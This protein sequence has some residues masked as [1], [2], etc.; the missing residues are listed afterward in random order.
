MLKHFN[1]TEVE[2]VEAPELEVLY[3][4]FALFGDQTRYL[5]SEKLRVSL[6]PKIMPV[7]D[8]FP[9]IFTVSDLDEF[10]DF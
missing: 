4:L 10:F 8:E 9:A 2:G 7:F 6:L 5:A 3:L 1:F